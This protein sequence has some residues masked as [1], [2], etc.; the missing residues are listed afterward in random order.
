MVYTAKKFNQTTLSQL[1]GCGLGMRLP[2]SIHWLK[3]TAIMYYTW[4]I[5]TTGGRVLKNP[6]WLKAPKLVHYLLNF[7]LS[8]QK[9]HFTHKWDPPSQWACSVDMQP[10]PFDVWAAMAGQ[11]ASYLYD[12]RL[13]TPST[14]ASFVTCG[15][16][17]AGMRTSGGWSLEKA[18]QGGTVATSKCWIFF[19]GSECWESHIIL[20]MWTPPWGKLS[21]VILWVS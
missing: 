13:T 12:S 2:L 14:G 4:Y 21:S 8:R 6:P 10:H 19:R 9:Q 18:G 16:L 11:T 3:S 1:A 5:M 20:A 15:W 17:R 7:G